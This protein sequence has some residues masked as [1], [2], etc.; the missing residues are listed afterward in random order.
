[1]KHKVVIIA[2]LTVLAA[3]GGTIGVIAAKNVFKKNTPLYG[4]FAYKNADGSVATVTMTEQNAHFENVDFTTAQKNAAF[5]Y[6]MDEYKE[7]E[8]KPDNEEL[9]K[10]IDALSSDMHYDSLFQGKTVDYTETKFIEEYSQ[11]YYY[12]S[13]DETG[14]YGLSLCV[15]LDTKSLSIADMLF[16]L[17]KKQ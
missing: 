1:M 13:N 14:P 8:K 16:T 6:A 12:I 11:Y 10:K 15:D 17:Q 3:I 7:A 5:L 4:T 2:S 9:E